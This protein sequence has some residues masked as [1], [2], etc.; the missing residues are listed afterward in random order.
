MR[1]MQRQLRHS[2]YA[3]VALI[4]VGVS[5]P[6]SALAEESQVYE[7]SVPDDATWQRLSKQIGSDRYGKFIIDLKSEKTY[8]FDVNLF[9]LHSDFVFSV[10]LKTERTPERNRQYNLNYTANKPR[11]VLGY[12]TH[13]L[14]ADM[15]TYAFWEGDDIDAEGIQSVYTTLKGTFFKPEVIFR[16]D[17]PKQEKQAEQVKALGLKT[18][19]NDAL[20][21]AS[22]YQMFN[23]G[24]AVGRLRIVP[25][26]TPYESLIFDR[27]DIVILQES[28]P[29]ISPVSGILSAVFST[30]LSH[31]NLRARA[32]KIPNAGFVDARKVH[33]HL[34]GE[35]VFFSVN[36]ATHFIRKATPEEIAAAEAKAAEARTVKLPKADTYQRRLKALA[37]LGIDDWRAYGTKSANL[38]AIASAR[39]LD[40][41][42]PP[43]FCIPFHHYASHMQRHGLD[44][45]LS[46]MLRDERWSTKPRWRKQATRRL[47]ERIKSADIDTRLADNIE[48]MVNSQLSGRG[49]FIRSSTNAE[50]LEGFNGAGL[51]D[52][53]GNV[54]GR[55]A[56]V[57]AVKQVW[58]SLW[59]FRAVEERELY[60]ISHH[61]VYAAILIQYGIDATAAGVLVTTNLFDPSDQNSYTIN[62][63]RGLG[64]RVV[65]GSTV[66]EQIIFDVVNNGTKII[67]RSDDPT[68]LVF[69]KNGGIIEIPN[70]DRGVIL[71]EERSKRLAHTVRS[72]VRLIPSKQPLDIEWALTGE[73]VWILQA[74]PFIGP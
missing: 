67:S 9:R 62:A 55:K 14:K 37:E 42:I 74:R 10:L 53:V 52:T 24:E 61:D 72:F 15:F 18:T 12:L 60:G 41:N 56:L 25:I 63:K 64:I 1:A 4:C 32:W 48:S 35:V 45:E 43:G 69:D 28:Y 16:P 38:G 22:D 20:Y 54:M 23:P 70:P 21:K 19:T 73:K 33:G 39:L 29:D 44:L 11:F 57:Q 31:V 40:V 30:P 3:I 5:S 58:A 8:F 68:M 6:P 50:D 66:P 51:Y 26:G 36:D 65:E 47:R 2:L 17:S 49:V 46:Q 59:N 13:H 34:D 7:T 27:R 71:D